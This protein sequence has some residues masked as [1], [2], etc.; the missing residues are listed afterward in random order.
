VT[1]TPGDWVSPAQDPPITAV[2]LPLSRPAGSGVP[3][4][5][6]GAEP[7][8]L[9]REP[10]AA[11]GRPGPWDAVVAPFTVPPTRADEPALSSGT[12]PP[13]EHR[14]PAGPWPGPAEPP[15]WRAGTPADG[16]ARERRRRLVLAFVAAGGAVAVAAVV[17]LAFGR[18]GGAHHPDSGCAGA[19]SGQAKA[20]VTPKL[21]YRTVERDTGY[22]EGTV[23]LVNRGRTP[24]RAWTLTFTYPGADIRNAWDVRLLRKGS[25]VVIAAAPAAG[26]IAPGKRFE[27]RFGGSGRPGMPTACRL[28]GV[29]CAFVG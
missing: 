16:P 18:L 6:G 4:V 29:P 17:A 1:H 13:A 25:D 23:T 28:N 8:L 20:A 26:P 15:S 11:R 22:F 5:P 7:P 12:L 2:D 3:A 14:P 24:M 9:T 27:V 10:D 21:R 19:C